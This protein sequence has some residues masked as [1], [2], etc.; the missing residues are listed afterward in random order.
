M[1]FS[2]YY[3]NAS[4]KIRTMV[5]CY[6]YN[7]TEICSFASPRHLHIRHLHPRHIDSRSVP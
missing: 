6:V 3:L 1:L 4:F 5:I 2:Y 7:R